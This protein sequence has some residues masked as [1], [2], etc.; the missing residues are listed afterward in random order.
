MNW[1]TASLGRSGGVGTEAA[2]AAARYP[3]AGQFNIIHVPSGLKADIMVARDDAFNRSRFESLLS[4]V[5][6]EQPTP[7]ASPEDVILKKLVY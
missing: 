3:G 5:V 4:A 6:D 2:D 7:F 1:R